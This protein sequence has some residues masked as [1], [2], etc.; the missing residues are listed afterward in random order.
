MKISLIGMSGVGKSYWAKKLEE[1]G[2]KRFCCDDLIEEKLGEEL[3]ALGHSGIQDVAKWMGQPFDPQYS[4]TSKLYIEYETETLR[5][6]LD[7]IEKEKENIV[8]DT[9]GSVILTG[10]KLL[11]RLSKL[12]SIVYLEASIE[13]RKQLYEVF[14]KEPKPV[15]WGD[16]FNK[17]E[18]ESDFD[19]LKRCYPELL[20]F[21]STKYEELADFKVDY[22]FLRKPDSSSEEFITFLINN[23]FNHLIAP[24]KVV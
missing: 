14:I 20:K 12:T 17:K 10:E 23:M 16:I 5:G 2:F 18:N 7:K 19:A 21:R 4:A 13:F 22:T 8:I 1:K 9:T 6:I 15:I 11:A 3:S 24:T